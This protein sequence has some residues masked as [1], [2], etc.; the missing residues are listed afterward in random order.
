M[1]LLFI[2]HVQLYANSNEAFSNPY[3]F[4]GSC[5]SQGDWTAQALYN[6]EQIKSFVNQLKNDPNCSSM[7]NNLIENLEN[8]IQELQKTKNDSE[9]NK[10]SS[11]LQLPKE[12][13]EFRA[14]LQSMNAQST[15][16]YKSDGLFALI[17]GTKKL[18]TSENLNPAQAQLVGQLRARINTSVES[19]FS[20]FSIFTSKLPDVQQCLT[21]SNLTSSLLS[22]SVR[23]ISAFL[24]SGATLNSEKVANSIAQISEAARQVKFNE[25][26]NELNKA[27]FMQSMSCIIELTSEAYC[28]AR[29]TQFLQSS[30]INDY[31]I[32]T[33][34][35]NNNNTSQIIKSNLNQT[36]ENQ[37]ESFFNKMNSTEAKASKNSVKQVEAEADIV[38][39]RAKLKSYD[40]KLLDP[41]YKNN[42]DLL[43]DPSYGLFI[44]S[45]HVANINHWIQ[46]I[47]LGV[48]PKLDTDAIFKNRVLETANTFLQKVN[49]LKGTVSQ[50]VTTIQN[51]SKLITKKSMT[52]KLIDTIVENLTT[53]RSGDQNFFIAQVPAIQI[54]FVLTGIPMPPQVSGNTG[55]TFVQRMSYDEYFQVNMNSIEQFNDPGVMLNT[56]QTNLNIIVLAA[57]SSMIEYYN[58]WFIVDKTLIIQKSL[59]GVNYSIYD[60]FVALKA[61]LEH[62]VVKIDNHSHGSL[63]E[64]RL[65]IPGIQELI[66]RLDKI[67]KAYEPLSRLN[68][69]MDQKIIEIGQCKTKIIEKKNEKNA[70]ESE[71]VSSCL[72]DKQLLE[73]ITLEMPSSDKHGSQKKLAHFQQAHQ[74]EK[75]QISTQNIVNVYSKI[76]ETVFEEFNVLLAR[77]SFISNRMSEYIETDYIISKRTVPNFAKYEN[78][79]LTTTGRILIERLVNMTSGNIPSSNLDLANAMSIHKSTNLRANE[80][81]FKSYLMPFLRQMKLATESSEYSNFDYFMRT[82][83]NIMDD[84]TLKSDEKIKNHNL[85]LTDNKASFKDRFLNL[86]GIFGET[87]SK[88]ARKILS[89]SWIPFAYL[90]HS[91]R[92]N[93]INP[94]D[95]KLLDSNRRQGD[96]EFGSLKTILAKY[97]TQVLAFNGWY[98]F[99]TICTNENLY[100][101]LYKNFLKSVDTNDPNKNEF[102]KKFNSYYSVMFNEKGY[103]A[104]RGP[105]P[106]DFVRLKP[107]HQSEN[108]YRSALNQ[109]QRICALR[110]Y[111]R[112]NQALILTAETSADK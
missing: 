59:T 42:P 58:K 63:S 26:T 111:V 50:Q 99:K 13:S 94:V 4:A 8:S 25:I 28:S 37:I 29:D 17:K 70:V 83:A 98:E 44:L 91:D 104:L 76:V 87:Q 96:T 64:M 75:M 89:T 27:Q 105:L 78:E 30:Y 51:E 36:Q 45:H 109:S 55:G 107:I 74:L 57:N 93:F 7:T 66:A 112:R 14:T 90:I 85:K 103:E 82:N 5:T 100:S 20:N 47:Q 84:F 79:I 72:K 18:L 80:L 2:Q 68:D 92:Y 34:I 16:G 32:E 1:M 101:P 65:K 86:W 106:P 71:E 6:S 9:L 39:F 35:E 52:L 49:T 97:C 69:L 12:L 60:S 54:P 102:I 73:L 43:N 110:D 11:I 23:T 53:Q 19:A 15:D 95:Y 3:K 77:S 56:I 46:E 31:F 33:R 88:Y 81:A 21:D 61:Y 22:M 108:V 41:N 10:N 62:L 40:Q 38:S 24:Q 48:D 67:I